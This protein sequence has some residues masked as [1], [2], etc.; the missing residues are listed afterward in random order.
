MDYPHTNSGSVKIMKAFYECERMMARIPL[1]HIF[2]KVLISLLSYIPGTRELV[3]KVVGNSLKRKR[4]ANPPR[5]KEDY[6]TYGAVFMYLT[7]K[8]QVCLPC[9]QG[10]LP[11]CLDP[12][13]L[14]TVFR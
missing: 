6:I 5:A 8:F 2:L 13:L 1:A 12:F 4:K 10:G 7:L 3:L 9:E 11:H 14:S